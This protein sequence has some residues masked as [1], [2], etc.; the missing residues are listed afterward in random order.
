MT[1]LLPCPFYCGANNEYMPAVE[2]SSHWQR[3]YVECGWCGLE[4]PHKATKEEAI[5]YWNN[6]RNLTETEEYIRGFN[7]AKRQLIE[8]SQKLPDLNKESEPT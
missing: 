4:S 7:E 2:Y 3:Y 5:F 8:L 6:R 1:K